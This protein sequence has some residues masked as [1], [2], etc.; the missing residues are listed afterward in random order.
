MREREAAMD[1]VNRV[2][3]L[4][5]DQTQVLV[6]NASHSVAEAAKVMLDHHVGCLVVVDSENKVVGI[7]TERD[8]VNKV[9]A[10]CMDPSTTLVSEIA[11]IPVIFCSIDTPL[12]QAQEMMAQNHI[13]HL[14][15]V[16][17]GVAIGMISSRDVLEYQ[18]SAVKAIIR[19]QSKAIRSLEDQYPGIT[20]FQTDGA[21]RI[22]I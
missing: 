16:E 14:P 13:R 2:A 12:T 17:N 15:I 18:L 20:E 9:V 22:V 11:T 1:K 21:G 19:R 6:V 5:K 3:T 10:T 8:I 7:L 4:L